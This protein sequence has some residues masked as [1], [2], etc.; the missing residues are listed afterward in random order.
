MEAGDK[1]EEVE[2]GDK[3]EESKKIDGIPENVKIGV[4]RRKTGAQY[5]S[6]IF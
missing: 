4:R 6:E 2:A 1:N 5:L 3:N